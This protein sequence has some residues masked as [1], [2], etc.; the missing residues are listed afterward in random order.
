M[1]SWRGSRKFL[2]LLKAD[3]EVT[4]TLPPEELEPLF[5]EQYHLRYVDEIFARLGLTETQ[6][7]S[8]TVTPD[9]LAPRAI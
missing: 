5:N 3:P 4:A 9:D 1:K 6:W 7:Q 2:S 8:E